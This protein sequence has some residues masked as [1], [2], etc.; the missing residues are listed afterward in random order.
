MEMIIYAH[1]NHPGKDILLKQ[2]AGS[3][4]L[5]PVM[6]FDFDGL[7]Q[8]LKTTISGKVIIVFLISSESELDHLIANR[9]RLF[10]IRFIII[11]P[12]TGEALTGKGLSLQPRYL[13]YPT[14]D[15]SDV[16][17]VLEKMIPQKTI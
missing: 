7:F 12:G 5:T 6:V 8:L 13:G 16:C 17:T 2:I 11:L 10:N 15:H 4:H 9:A 3:T 1:A 14:R